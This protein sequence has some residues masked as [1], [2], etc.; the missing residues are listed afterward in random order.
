LYVCETCFVQLREKYSLGSAQEEGVE[1]NI[2][3]TE[4][5]EVSEN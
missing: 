2:C 4:W 5:E 3:G 1:G